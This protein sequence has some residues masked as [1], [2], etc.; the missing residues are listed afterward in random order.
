MDILSDIELDDLN[1]VSSV[2]SR[3]NECP[4]EQEKTNMR[5]GKYRK[6]QFRMRDFFYIHLVI[7]VVIGLLSGMIIYLIENYSRLKNEEIEVSYVN[8]WF[9]SCTCICG[10]GLTTLDFAKLS[11]A[12]QILL[13]VLTFFFG[14]TI[15]TLPILA[16][17]AYAQKHTNGL[18][19]DN[20]HGNT[21]RTSHN[22]QQSSTASKTSRYLPS[23][24]ER[25]LDLLPTSQEIRYWAYIT[26]IILIL[27]FCLSLYLCYFIIIG[28]W[29]DARYTKNELAEG[30]TTIS[31]WYT[32]IVIVITGFNQNGLT[33]FSGG[34]GRFVNDVYMNIF[35]MMVFYFQ[36][37]LKHL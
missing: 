21:V 26:I 29:L 2:A 31:P 8:A 23:E 9:I 13:L 30:N 25:K 6:Y 28:V 3:Q 18:T 12:S 11:K 1:D 22:E 34:M 33:P 15:S 36:L 19:L 16:I 32:S 27:V 10:C 37:E 20:D 35:V 14:I 4:N 24:L 17:K 7:F 5:H